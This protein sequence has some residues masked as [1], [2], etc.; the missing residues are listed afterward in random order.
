MGAAFG[1]T[2]FGCGSE[3]A[4]I[5]AQGD[6]ELILSPQALLAQI[7]HIVV[8]C[9]ENRSFD[10]Y[11]GPRKFL[12]GDALNG[13][14]GTETNPAPDGSPVQVFNLQDYTPADPPH[15][16]SDCHLQ[17]NN[18]ANDGFVISHAGPE[19]HNAM[20]YHVRSQIPIHY[21]LADYF[22]SC[23]NY[24]ASV[25]GPT[26][27]NRFYLHGGTSHGVKDST[28]VPGF[29]SIFEQLAAAGIPAVNYFSDV[30]WAAAA[31]FKTSG[32]QHISQFFEGALQGKLPKFSI[33]DPQFLGPGSNDDHPDKDIRLGQA[34]I[35]TI[36]RA[37][38]KSPLWNNVLFLVTYD[39]H[40]GFYDHVAPPTTTDP[41]PGFEQL[42][43]RVPALAI[44]PYVRQ[45]VAVSTVLEH[46]SVLKTLSTRF[47]LPP[48]TARVGAAN[49]LA[50]VIDPNFIQNPQ[51]APDMP[52]LVISTSS[53]EASIAELEKKP[54]HAHKEL[55][56]AAN[57]GVIPPGLD[58]RQKKGLG[59]S[60]VVLDWGV[61][62]GAVKMVP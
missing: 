43:F 34:L 5:I 1:A 11:L 47:N 32:F 14:S 28:P 36:Y 17:W 12:E 56:D 20:G 25:M 4:G 10:H 26:W 13:L 41:Y 57:A 27:P 50:A 44:G 23:D 55:D 59:S 46:A 60:K 45:G 53:L 31:Y 37:L 30:P 54:E 8:L 58:K 18:G 16:W 15:E 42:G 40:G 24:F 61:K 6:N 51:P 33:I 22:T 35:A 7:K 48:L 29:A 49:S 39:E 2:A 3:G 38:A 21:A 52:P 9:Q 19:Q 62:L